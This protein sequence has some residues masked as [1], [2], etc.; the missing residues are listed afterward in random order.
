MDFIQN[1]EKKTEEEVFEKNKISS[2]TQEFHIDEPTYL[3]N[4]ISNDY[5]KEVLA[6]DIITEMIFPNKPSFYY[7]EEDLSIEE[8][9]QE[10]HSSKK[11]N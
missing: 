1:I 2:L 10:S 7:V 8:D 9:N 4:E 3:I 5:S 6:I 11:N